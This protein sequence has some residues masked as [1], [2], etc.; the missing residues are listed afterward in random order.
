MWVRKHFR[1]K[2]RNYPKIVWNNEKVANFK[3]LLINNND[4]IQRLASD[5]ASKPVDEVVN[6]F[7]QFLHDKAF[8]VF[9]KTYSNRNRPQGQ[10]LNKEWFDDSCKNAKREF[11][12]ARNIF[13]RVKNDE[14][15][16]NFTRARTKYNRAKK[17]AQ[18]KFKLMEGKRLNDLAK[19]DT[20]KFWKSIKKSYKKT[21]NA[22]NSLTV[23]QL[24]DHFKSMFGEQ[25]EPD[26]NTEPNVNINLISEELDTEFSYSELQSAVFSQNNNKTPGMDN[27]TSEIIKASYDLICP[28]LLNLYNH[29]YET[30]DY[31]RS[32]DDSPIFKKEDVNDAQNYLGITL[33]N[34]L[35]KI[36]SQLLLNRLTNW[37]RKY[38]KITGN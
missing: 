37:T 25:T 22:E 7:T 6:N 18:Q 36:Y 31:P 20:R 35:A 33:I 11:T 12:S 38:E 28:Y 19:K 15:R 1:K 24:H 17:K 5:V 9:G 21:N 4:R 30:G 32:W 10:K 3:T 16:I 8:E 34:I 27:I 29:M 14:C 26:E 13:S 23:E 2:W